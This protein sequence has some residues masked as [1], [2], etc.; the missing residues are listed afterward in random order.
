MAFRIHRSQAWLSQIERGNLEPSFLDLDKRAL[1][2]RVCR[3][4]FSGSLLSSISAN[5][6]LLIQ[7][8]FIEGPL[9][10]TN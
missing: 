5:Q 4:Q 8:Y 7:E 2:P 3:T 9:E 1:T 10:F 6:K